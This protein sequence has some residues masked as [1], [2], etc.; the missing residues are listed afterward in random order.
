MD[1]YSKL[2]E[3]EELPEFTLN[4]LGDEVVSS[5][6]LIGKIV[7]LNLFIIKCPHCRDSHRFFKKH[8]PKYLKH[9]DFRFY[10][11]G[12]DHNAKDLEE[13]QSRKGFEF[14]MAEDPD[15]EVYNLF[16]TRKVPRNYLF[17]REGKIIYQKRGFDE[18]D[19]NLLL[20]KIERSLS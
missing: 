11:I 17:N 18:D 5:I 6:Q 2:K 19:Y 4:V 20:E 8:L 15:K 9:P 12:R 3:G 1:I 14:P 16:A 13:Y 7:L 10:A